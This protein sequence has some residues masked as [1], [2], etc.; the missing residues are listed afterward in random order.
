MDFALSFH[1]STPTPGSQQVAGDK[2]EA[3][4]CDRDF[5]GPKVFVGLSFSLMP[6]PIR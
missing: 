4:I 3:V 5:V 6:Q 1:L 2:S